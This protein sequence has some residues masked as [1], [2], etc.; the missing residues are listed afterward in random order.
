MEPRDLICQVAVHVMK[1]QPKACCI[2]GTTGKLHLKL[3][4]LFLSKSKK[5]KTL[6]LLVIFP[7][8]KVL[9]FFVSI[10]L[11]GSIISPHFFPAPHFP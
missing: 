3:L 4:K 9:V 1:Q 5:I 2:S 6:W 11:R 7:V 8:N 10:R